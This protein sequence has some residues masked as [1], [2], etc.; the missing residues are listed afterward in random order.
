MKDLTKEEKELLM[1]MA[2]TFIS[3]VGSTISKMKEQKQRDEVKDILKDSL[4]LSDK[5]SKIEIK[6]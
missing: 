5:I 6:K 3:N 4:A 1:N 2:D